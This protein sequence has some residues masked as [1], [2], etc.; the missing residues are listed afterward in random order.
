MHLP[1]Y[2]NLYFAYIDALNLNKVVEVNDW[3]SNDLQ[4]PDT[5]HL[6]A[7]MITL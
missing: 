7:L 1:P 2:F 3:S 4:Y 5:W 6:Q